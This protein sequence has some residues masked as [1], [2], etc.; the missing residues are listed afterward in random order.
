MKRC[1][2]RLGICAALVLCAVTAGAVAPATLR[3]LLITG[4]HDF[5]AEPFLEVF[6]AASGITVTHARHEGTTATAYERANPASYDVV[7]LYDMPKD[8]TPSQQASFVEI[9][10]RGTG[11][12]ALHHA[13]VSAQGWADYER[14]IGGRY[15]EAAGKSGVVTAEVGYA[16]GVDVP[17]TVAARNHPVAAGVGDFTI[18]DE[19]YWGFRVGAD[20]TPLLTTTHPKSGKPLGWVRTEGRS[21]VV[22][23]QLGHDRFAYENANFRQLVAQ[24]IRWA[25]GR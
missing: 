8:V 16:H 22:Y 5:E 18:R 25:S 15:P 7:V 4:G 13:I 12:V 3:V 17:V 24:S 20:V 19:I 1:T 14:I 10:R 6:R 9:F 11:L 23:L 21:R 2:S